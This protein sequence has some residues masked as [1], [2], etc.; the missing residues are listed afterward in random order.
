MRLSGVVS[1]VT[2]AACLAVLACGGSPSEQQ[3]APTSGLTAEQPQAPPG[4]PLLTFEEQGLPAELAPR[5]QTWLG[6]FDAM[7]ERR[8]IR[9]LTVYNLGGYFLDGPNQRGLTYDAAQLFEKQL[10]A[11]LRTGLLEV[12]VV[13]VPVSRDELIPAL[14][15]GYGDIAAANLTITPERQKLVDFSEPLLSDVREVVVTGPASPP[16]ASVDDL[17]G[18]RLHVRRSSSYWASLSR[19]NE[20]WRGAGQREVELVAAPEELQDEDLLEMVNAGLLPMAIVDSHKAE[21]WAR[22][23]DVITVRDDLAV[24]SGG[25]IAWAFRKGT[26][27][28]NMLLNRYLKDMR[29][30]RNAL[31]EDQLDR[32]RATVELF[33]QYSDRYGFDHLMIAAQG[34]Q[35]SRLDQSARSRA[36]AIGVMQL[37]PSTAADP[38]VGIKNIERLENN[39]HAGVKYMRFLRDRYF[40]DADMDELNKTLFSFAAYNAG[41]ARVRRLRDAAQRSGLDPNR[42]FDHVERMAAKQIGRETVQYVS[43]IYKYY[44]AYRLSSDQL[45]RQDRSRQAMTPSG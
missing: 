18:Q 36:G 41:P 8:V 30:V 29:W 27:Q 6:D 28:G 4:T 1:H 16:L 34:Y 5:E 31:A 21:F 40:E 38:N 10:N 35:E 13:I 33:R 24:R 12:H 15:E 25:Q 26:L 45:E 11:S 22:V 39:I 37:L 2:V 44:V 42:W 17:A 23:F 14:V 19:L 9:L 20:L 7:R 32:F 3:A 43:N